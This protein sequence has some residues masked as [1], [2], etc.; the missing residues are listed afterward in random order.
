M[1]LFYMLLKPPILSC[2]LLFAPTTS[3][4][5]IRREESSLYSAHIEWEECTH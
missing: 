4:L 1:V 5:L 3:Y 2:N